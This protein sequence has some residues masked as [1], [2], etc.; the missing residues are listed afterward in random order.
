MTSHNYIPVRE[1]PINSRS[2]TGTLSSGSRFESSLERDLMNI[3]RFDIN[4]DRFIEQPLKI[5]FVDPKGVSRTYTP[6]ILIIHRRDILPAKLM[7]QILGEVKYREDLRANF[8]SYKPKFKA[9]MRYAKAQGWEFR[10]FTEREIRT[11]F[12]KN[13]VFLLKYKQPDPY[14]DSGDILEV[15][16]KLHELRETNVQTLLVS[17]HRDKWNQARLLPVIW[18]LVAIRRIGNDLTQPITMSSP[19]WTMRK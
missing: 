5:P 12:L 11:P 18:H 10:I 9:A 16:E 1:I 19:I 2:L 15:L 6:D 13:A 14:P 3:L 8:A 7:P 17:I 4:V